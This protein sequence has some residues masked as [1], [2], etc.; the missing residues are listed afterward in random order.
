MGIRETNRTHHYALDLHSDH[1]ITDLVLYIQFLLSV[2]VLVAI[3]PPYPSVE[4]LSCWPASLCWDRW[5]LGGHLLAS[6]NVCCCNSGCNP[7]PRGKRASSREDHGHP[8]RPAVRHA[9]PITVRLFKKS[10]EGYRCEQP[11]LNVVYNAFMRKM[12]S[13]KFTHLRHCDGRAEVAA[14]ACETNEL[15]MGEPPLTRCRQFSGTCQLR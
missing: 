15:P 1:Q 8:C 11:V 7:A 9:S 3:T 4:A 13:H 12:G 10:L 5:V 2:L 14:C 6:L